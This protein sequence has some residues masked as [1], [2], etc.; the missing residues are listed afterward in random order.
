MYTFDRLLADV[1]RVRGPLLR[2]GADLGGTGSYQK[3][4]DAFN[5]YLTS[6]IQKK[7]TLNVANFCKLGWR[8]EEG[9]RN[10]RS[11]RIRPH[12]QMSDS[13]LRVYGIECKHHPSVSDK[14]LTAIE[15][16]NFS[17]AAIRFTQDLTKEN[18]FMGMRAIV[19]QIGEAVANGYTISIPFEIGKLRSEGHRGVRFDFAAELYLSE[20]LQIPDSALSPADAAAYKPSHSFSPPTKEALSLS[21]SA[22][23][24]PPSKGD[25]PS[26]LA[27]ECGGFSFKGAADGYSETVVE[28]VHVAV[29]PR[30]PRVPSR[31]GR[32]PA[33][34]AR[35]AAMERYFLEIAAE[36]E[37]AVVEKEAWEAH[38]QRC[39]AED[40][41]DSAT[42]KA[43]ALAHS[44]QLRQ[45]M[46]QVEDRRKLGQINAHVFE[47]G[48]MH[49]FPNFSEIPEADFRDYVRDRRSTLRHDLTEQIEHKKR[50]QQLER[51]RDLQLEAYHNE[52]KRQEMN[53][54][55]RDEFARRERDRAKLKEAWMLDQ[56]LRNVKKGIEAHFQA[57]SKKEDIAGLVADLH[58]ADRRG[59]LKVAVPK[60]QVSE[61]SEGG[62]SPE[63]N[64]T[65][66][67]GHCGFDPPSSARPPTGS[68][69]RMPI[70]AAASLAL[71]K[72][73]LA[74]SM[75]H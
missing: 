12:F 5:R 4:W 48:S 64:R 34:L 72:Q 19:Q 44:E 69:R 59:A 16:F 61:R 66:G 11:A 24:R 45:Q 51:A 29:T 47:Q 18:V 10:G 27:D 9:G 8:V 46:Q 7:Q 52:A 33:E 3:V 26:V 39:H 65:N 75:R 57:A 49:D 2:G 17:K 22:S 63:A 32:G 73:K 23:N 31:S 35:Q 56:Q 55:K 62:F 50:T 14:N 40:E 74:E 37:A 28:H 38:V 6:C 68:V 54:A 70:G 15:E 43:F 60:L 53:A 58:F 25:D 71:H 42:R 13:F 67:V 1:V 41:R 21:L 30:S 36:A 20:G